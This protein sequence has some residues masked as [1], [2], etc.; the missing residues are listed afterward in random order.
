MFVNDNHDDWD[1]QLPY[2]MAAY[3]ATEHKSTSC[4]PNLLMLNRETTCPLDLMVGYPPGQEPQECHVAY[5]EWVR[6]TMRGAHEL[7][8]EALGQAAT[9]QSRYYNRDIDHRQF[10]KGDWVWR[11]YPPK[12]NQKTWPSMGWSVLGFGRV[13]CMDLQDSEIFYHCTC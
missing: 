11:H 8:F 6:Q 7:A 5:V 1:E 12:A 9:R 2:V 13:N 10:S 4:T 3:R